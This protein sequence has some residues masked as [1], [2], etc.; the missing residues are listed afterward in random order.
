MCKTQLCTTVKGAE[1][2]LASGKVTGSEWLA[3]SVHPDLPS[4]SCGPEPQID[5]NWTAGSRRR[6]R[7]FLRSTDRDE[8]TFTLHG[9]LLGCPIPASLCSL[10]S[11]HT[12][13][14]KPQT[15]SIVPMVLS[16]TLPREPSSMAPRLPSQLRTPSYRFLT[17]LASLCLCGFLWMVPDRC[18]ACLS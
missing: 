17:E 14:A 10:P 12:A 6:Y 9:D 15:G 18:P 3:G 5:S 11:E 4:G 2:L 8:D 7:T 16:M 13:G 1:S